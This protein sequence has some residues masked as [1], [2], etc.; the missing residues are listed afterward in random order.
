MLFIISLVIGFGEGYRKKQ[1][2]APIYLGVKHGCSKTFFASLTTDQVIRPDGYENLNMGTATGNITLCIVKDVKKRVRRIRY[3]LQ[4]PN[5]KHIVAIRLTIEDVQKPNGRAVG[6]LITPRGAGNVK[7]GSN[8][9]GYWRNS[10]HVFPFTTITEV[11]DAIEKEIAYVLVRT[12]DGVGR[13]NTK[14][15]GHFYLCRFILW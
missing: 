13:Q 15:G 5:V 10:S 9:W 4:V 8:F 6:N 2:P 12:D 14:A 7:L 11:A 3:H 1:C